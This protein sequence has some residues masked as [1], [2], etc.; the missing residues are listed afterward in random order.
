MPCVSGVLSQHVAACRVETT[1]RGVVVVDAA[2]RV[3][4]RWQCTVQC[5]A[6]GGWLGFSSCR[7]GDSRLFVRS[8]VRSFARGGHPPSQQLWW[9]CS[10]VCRV[11]SCVRVFV[12]VFVRSCV[13]LCV[14]SCVFVRSC[15]FAPL[16]PSLPPSIYIY[17]YISIYLY[18]SIYLYI[19][20][21]LYFNKA[22]PPR[23]A[24]WLAGCWCV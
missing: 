14:R 2:Y 11:C 16:P 9:R 20:F 22:A 19:Y 12:R 18:L 13:C 5:G 7:H 21:Y 1:L 3:G 23:P 10:C 8:F 6:V 15:A 24:G 17:I 4:W